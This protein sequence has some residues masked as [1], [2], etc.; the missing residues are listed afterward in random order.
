MGG[1]PDSCCTLG[2]SGALPGWLH[3][4]DDCKVPNNHSFLA[5]KLCTFVVIRLGA[6]Q[7]SQNMDGRAWDHLHLQS[8]VHFAGLAS[9]LLLFG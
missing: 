7:C 8:G 9:R 5:M 4:Y 1:L 3:S 6:M 2:N